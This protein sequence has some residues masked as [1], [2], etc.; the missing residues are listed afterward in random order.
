M[1]GSF[2][3]VML[4]GALTRDPEIKHTSSNTAVANF[5]LAINRRFKAQSGEQREETTFVDCEAWGRTGEIITQHFGKGSPIFVEGRLK[6][7]EWDDKATGAKRSK[8][9]V[10]VENFQFLGGEK[11]EGRRE[12]PRRKVSEPQGAGSGP[13]Y[14][15]IPF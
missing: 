6:L 4:M 11:P 7:S 3:K 15:D 10:V 14:G 13:D 9:S 5:G 8:L 1:A 2:N 12:S